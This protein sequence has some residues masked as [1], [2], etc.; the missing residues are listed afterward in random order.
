MRHCDCVSRVTVA[1]C[2]VCCSN[3]GEI[4]VTAQSSNPPSIR[5]WDFATGACTSVLTCPTVDVGSLSFS[6]DDKLLSS[7]GHDSH[8]RVRLIYPH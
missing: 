5:V 2:A 7:Y 8:T 3:S 1:L 4:L 6:R